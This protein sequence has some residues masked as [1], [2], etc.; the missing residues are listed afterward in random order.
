M[1]HS[2]MGPSS[3][4]RRALCP[5]SYHA[6]KALPEAESSAAAKEGSRLHALVAEAL[7][8]NPADELP[9][10]VRDCV[11]FAEKIRPENAAVMVEE[12]IPLGCIHEAIEMGTPDLAY[13]V[14]FG[15]GVVVDWKFGHREPEPASSNPQLAALAVGLADLHQLTAVT[16]H[17]VCPVL[18]KVSSHRFEEDGLAKVRAILRDVVEAATAP[19][20]P[21]V[22]SEKACRYCRA[23]ATCH[24]VLAGA[25]RLPV[26]KAPAD[27]Q[28][29]ELGKLLRFAKVVKEWAG[30]LEQRAVEMAVAGAEIPGWALAAGR[31]TR[32]W[33][34]SVTGNSLR[35]LAGVLGKDASAVVVQPPPAVASPALIERAWGKSEQVKEAG[36]QL[37]ALKPGKPKLVPADETG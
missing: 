25:E 26:A 5:G 33:R 18:G 29:A 31:P 34:D 15:D 13:A 10:V 30:K 17:V 24:A 2:L 4:E 21:R 35:E 6:E 9:D 36:K 20:A 16:V 7:K 11:A 37:V 1:Q 3:L 19:W 14:P 22:P 12:T 23:A 27:L 32:V 28:P 8:G